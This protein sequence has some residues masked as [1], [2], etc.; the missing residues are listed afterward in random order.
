MSNPWEYREVM[1]AAMAFGE[2]RSVE[3]VIAAQEARHEEQSRQ[4]KAPGKGRTKAAPAL[5]NKPLPAK[6]VAALQALL[7]KAGEAAADQV[8]STPDE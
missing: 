1:K 5:A 7:A 6:S 8:A 4:K 3:E 2:T